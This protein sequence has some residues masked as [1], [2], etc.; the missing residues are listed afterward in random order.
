MNFYYPP[1]F[2][3]KLTST[4]LVNG[5][6][7]GSWMWDCRRWNG[8]GKKENHNPAVKFTVQMIQ[9]YS[10]LYPFIYS[11]VLNNRNS[12]ISAVKQFNKS[13][14]VVRVKWLNYT[15]KTACL[16]LIPAGFFVI[17][18]Y[19]LLWVWEWRFNKTL[20]KLLLTLQLKQI[21]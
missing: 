10:L 8:T 19:Y 20:P 11:S 5:K 16:I 15:H 13:S 12:I 21:I 2:L 6:T 3:C 9:G 17:R 4:N 18:P 1:L 7:K 14:L